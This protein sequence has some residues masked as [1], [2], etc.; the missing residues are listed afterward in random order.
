MA[1]IA[2]HLMHEGKKVGRVKFICGLCFPRV[3]FV[4]W[5]SAKQSPLQKCSTPK[6]DV[7]IDKVVFEFKC[8]HHM[9]PRNTVTLVEI[10]E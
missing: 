4:T 6:S 2:Q 3:H 8:S 10:G 7:S 9:C 5:K 1:S